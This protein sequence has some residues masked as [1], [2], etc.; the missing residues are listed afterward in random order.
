[1][2]G[3]VPATWSAV[4]PHGVTVAEFNGVL[5]EDTGGHLVAIVDERRTQRPERRQDRLEGRVAGFA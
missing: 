3:R 4:Q 5:E 2:S 1:M